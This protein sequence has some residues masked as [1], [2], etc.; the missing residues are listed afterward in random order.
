[1]LKNQLCR[2]LSP[3]EV[4]NEAMTESLL[5]GS[6]GGAEKSGLISAV[7]VEQ[8]LRLALN[9]AIPICLRFAAETKTPY[10][11]LH[12]KSI[13]LPPPPPYLHGNEFVCNDVCIFNLFETPGGVL[14]FLWGGM[15]VSSSSVLLVLLAVIKWR[16]KP[17]GLN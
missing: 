10:R 17:K 2:L 14:G 8:K 5:S 12:E 13:S 1:M 6:Q 11:D 3:R 16:A 7:S 4:A 15:F 9:N